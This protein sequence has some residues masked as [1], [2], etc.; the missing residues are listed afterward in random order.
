MAFIDFCTLNHLNVIRR[1]FF[2]AVYVGIS[3][4]KSDAANT[5]ATATATNATA[6]VSNVN[7]EHALDFV[8]RMA[9]QK[10]SDKTKHVGNFGSQFSGIYV[11]RA[12]YAF[13]AIN[14]AQF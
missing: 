8:E 6:Q 9:N 12:R 7:V 4:Q 5:P 3:A 13:Q 11:T 14:T 2:Q 1:R 10:L